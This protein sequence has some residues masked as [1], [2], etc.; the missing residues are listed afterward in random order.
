MAGLFGEG[1]GGS[2][3][4]IA[5]S[6]MNILFWGAIVIAILVAL[7]FFA[8]WWKNRKSYNVPVTIFI[9]RSDNTTADVIHAVGGYFKSK[10]VGGITTFRLKRKGVGVVE[11]PPP[12]SR[13]LMGYNHELFLVQKGMDDFEPVLPKS[14]NFVTVEGSN[15]RLAVVDLKCINQDATAWKFDNEE[16]AKQRFTIHSFW[17]KYKDFIQMTIFI[18]IVFIAMYIMWQGLGEVASALKDVSSSLAPAVSNAPLV[19]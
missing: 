6:L 8:R 17:E 16:N 9:P 10:P 15:Q 12:P 19:S 5:S 14:F 2:L 11:L 4:G 18:F 3:G 13:Y 1:I 7:F